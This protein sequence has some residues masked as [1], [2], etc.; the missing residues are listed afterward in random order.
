MQ[1]H[2]QRSYKNRK[3]NIWSSSIWNRLITILCGLNNVLQVF[4]EEM[5]LVTP[6][7]REQGIIRL[8]RIR[9][10]SYCE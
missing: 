5:D 7:S 3:K 1:S 2:Q 6:K 9:D 10:N 8:F 4:S